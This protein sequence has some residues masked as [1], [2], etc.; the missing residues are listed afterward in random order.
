MNNTDLTVNPG[1][2]DKEYRLWTISVPKH[3]LLGG[4]YS[5]RLLVH[6]QRYR[7]SDRNKHVY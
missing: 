7:P 1:A 2:R 6:Q 5:R 4:W 3:L